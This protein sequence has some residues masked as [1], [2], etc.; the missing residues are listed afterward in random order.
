VRFCHDERR[1]R[2]R[3]MSSCG[4]S[5]C[6]VD[7]CFGHSFRESFPMH[8]LVSTLASLVHETKNLS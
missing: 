8:N 7:A 3:A 2:N 1:A 6:F 4:C 5:N